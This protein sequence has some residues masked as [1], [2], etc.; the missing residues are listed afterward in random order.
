MFLDR[1]LLGEARR[2][3][4]ILGATIG[5]GLGVALATVIQ[6]WLIARLVSLALV[7]LLTPASARG[8]LLGLAVA[9]LVRALLV[10]GRATTAAAASQRLRNRIRG[11]LAS[12]VAAL[13]PLAL[14][15]ERTG[16]LA[17]TLSDGIERLD[18]YISTY[19]PQL[20]LAAGI[21][22]G[23]II[24]VAV[25]DLLSAAVL[26]VTVPVIPM[27]MALIGGAAAA[28]SRRQWTEL[29]RLGAH[30]LEAVQ[31]LP[32][33]KILG[34]VRDEVAQIARTSERFREA[35][36]GVLRIA[37][38]SA[39]VLELVATIST[40]VVAV[41]VG[42][43]LLYGKLAFEPAFFVLLLA[44][45]VYGPLRKLGAAFHP[46]TQ[47]VAAAERIFELLET[48]PPRLERTPTVDQ[49]PA[50]HIRFSDVG[51]SY[52]EQ[53]GERP[54]ALDRI[55]LDIEPGTSLALAGPTGAGKSTIAALLLRFAVPDRGR[56]T[57]GGVPLD[58]I[59][60]AAWRRACA[61]VPQRPFI[62]P[63]SIAD[64]VR[65]ARPA[66]DLVAVERAVQLAGLEPVVARLPN[67]LDT[68]LGEGGA[69]LSGGELQRLALARAFLADA[70][71]LILDEPAAH[72]DPRLEEALGATMARLLEGRTALVI[73]HRL[74]T[75]RMASRIAVVEAGRI[76]E[77]GT[78]GELIEA[79]GL[80][81][82]LVGAG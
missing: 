36:M 9:T 76:V 21:P 17:G 68:P 16:E 59:E 28:K 60:L 11:R 35:T 67:E 46:G 65:L 34:R 66:A 39:L 31:G 22:L 42:L 82:R 70:P 2:E 61:W 8:P 3:S 37:F 75:L 4:V 62:L 69:G 56:I 43:R 5:C 52:P 24:L 81:A 6:A 80:Y 23:I 30:F 26:L 45:E 48:A 33:L 74:R 18:A 29:A 32:T 73:A 1:R 72:L 14:G 13:G 55:D 20:A 25:R 58:R 53:R 10:W 41:Q 15:Q 40:A 77:T 19:L 7:K 27:F 63:G 51:F 49:P 47:G 12:H 38:L 50:W 57:V 79:G 44:P 78:H 54:A 71:C 64:N